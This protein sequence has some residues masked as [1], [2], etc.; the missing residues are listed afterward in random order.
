[1]AVACFCRF[2]SDVVSLLS[3]GEDCEAQFVPK[4]S[5]EMA[6]SEAC[7]PAKVDIMVVFDNSDGTSNLTDPS[8]NSNKYLLLDVLG[9]LALFPLTNTER[10]TVLE[11]D[12][13]L[14]D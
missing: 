7:E 10:F 5:I 9:T 8:I 4:Q 14:E 12:I 13:S 11:R 1:M 3:G 2:L 6:P